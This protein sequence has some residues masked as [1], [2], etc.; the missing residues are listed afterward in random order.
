M[1]RP[2]AEAV[3]LLAPE[4]GAAAERAL[5]GALL[6]D[7]EAAGRVALR[8]GAVEVT[9]DT[10]TWDE[11]A[12]A[13]LA[14]LLGAGR[15]ATGAALAGLAAEAGAWHG[16]LCDRL[17]AAG[18]LPDWEAKVLWLFT[19]RATPGEDQA[20]ALRARLAAAGAEGGELA[21]LLALLRGAGLAP[22]LP[23]A[24]DEVAAALATEG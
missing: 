19:G 22:G 5:A 12:D 24:G 13:A 20:A 21:G 9:D 2:L 15:Q 8:D 14:L 3:V 11:V 16:R 1:A 17:V 6:R 4:G 23:A 10:P 7:L 18:A